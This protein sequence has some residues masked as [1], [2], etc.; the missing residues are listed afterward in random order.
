MS[1]QDELPVLEVDDAVE[2]G[3]SGEVSHIAFSRR[4]L[5][6]SDPKVNADGSSIAECMASL[7]NTELMQKQLQT[8]VLAVR[9][10]LYPCNAFSDIC[11][12]LLHRLP[13]VFQTPGLLE[14]LKDSEF[15]LLGQRA[16]VLSR[17]QDLA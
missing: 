10:P 16:S 15:E 11:M 8:P 13:C 5:Y 1:Y 9:P 3:E 17:P 7:L 2:R 6:C 14:M 12:H 4:G